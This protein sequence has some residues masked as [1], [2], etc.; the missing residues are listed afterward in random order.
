M[1]ITE[2]AEV[3]RAARAEYE[4]GGWRARQWPSATAYARHAAW[5]TIAPGRICGRDEC[6]RCDADEA[7]VEAALVAP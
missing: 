6:E 2:V 5:Q 3:V 1:E 4:S 7:V